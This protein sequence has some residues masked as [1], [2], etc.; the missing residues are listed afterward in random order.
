[1]S[2]VVGSTSLIPV[3]FCELIFNDLAKR[4]L[5]CA[6]TLGLLMY[7][8]VTCAA[9]DTCLITNAAF[10]SSL[11]FPEFLVFHTS[12]QKFHNPLRSW[13]IHL[14]MVQECTSLSVSHLSLYSHCASFHCFDNIPQT[15]LSHPIASCS[16]AAAGT[17]RSARPH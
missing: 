17:S 6:P 11:C 4:K 2:I 12:W 14:Y 15:N 3:F 5:K 1:M 10:L 9:R 13:L 8:L 16:T 7:M